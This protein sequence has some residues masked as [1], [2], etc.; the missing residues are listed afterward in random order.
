MKYAIFSD[1]H[2]NLEAF[3]SVVSKVRE[4]NPDKWVCA[5]DIVGYGADPNQ[6]V[7]RLREVN[8]TC[9]VGNHDHAALG[10]TR[11]DD[12]NRSA[13]EAVTWTQGIVSEDAKNYLSGLKLVENL[14]NFTVVHA[15]PI[16][17]EQWSYIFTTFEAL[18]NFKNFD[19]PLCF[20]GHSH[21][22]ILFTLT[23]QGRIEYSY[24]TN[25]SIDKNKRYIINVGSVGQPRDHN[26]EAAFA[27]YDD[28]LG[29]V[30]L[31][32]IPYDIEKAQKKII[33]AGLPQALAR[34]L[35][36]GE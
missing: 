28:V 33:S 23:E 30:V 13:Q 15:T 35:A 32:R 29:T 8:P 24:E 19:T 36:L 4:E 6:C 18:M 9:V 31:K 5:G 7:E 25:L 26:P 21:I 16:K 17:P 11:T 14:E 34:R 27:I 10:L 20:I 12:F 1:I 3:E 22:P 2:G